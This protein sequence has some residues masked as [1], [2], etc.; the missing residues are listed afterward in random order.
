MM[1]TPR[2]PSSSGECSWGLAAAAEEDASGD[3]QTVLA[4]LCQSN[5]GRS[6]RGLVYVAEAGQGW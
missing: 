3:I 5:V 2:S 6:G 1:A 4:L